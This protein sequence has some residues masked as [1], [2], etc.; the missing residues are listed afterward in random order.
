MAFIDFHSLPFNYIRVVGSTL[1]EVPQ[2]SEARDNLFY[3]HLMVDQS[4]PVVG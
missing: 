2:V 4:H 3:K 1:S